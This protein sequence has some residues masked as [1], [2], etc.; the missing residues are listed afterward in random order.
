M[1]RAT[2]P[3]QPPPEEPPRVLLWRWRRNPLRRPADLAQAWIALGLFLA[4]LAA[5]PAV[6]VLVGD[7]AHRHYQE[8]ARQQAATRHQVPAVLVDDAPRHPEPGS[9]EAEKALYPVTVRFTDREGH[10]RT[11]KADVRPALPAG[12]A[13]HIW[14]SATGEITEPPLTAE[15]VRSRSL[16]CAVVAV[17]SVALIGAAAYGYAARRLER[18][19]L[20]RW[21]TAWARTA[22]GWTASP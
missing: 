9:D 10:L 7:A 16:G 3:A 20:A 2:P 12:S 4:V 13:V 15:Q 5:T 19:N 18:H 17:L 8:T 11:T 14:A 1:A 21:D 22:P 6:M